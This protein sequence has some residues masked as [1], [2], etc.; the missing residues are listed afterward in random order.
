MILYE[1]NQ[2]LHSFT[3]YHYLRLL[4]TTNQSADTTSA[5]NPSAMGLLLCDNNPF[6]LQ[7]LD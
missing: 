4:Q 2:T 5:H 1:F 7:K 3:N 6:E